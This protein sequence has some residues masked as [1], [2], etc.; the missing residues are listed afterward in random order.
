MRAA[1]AHLLW[2]EMDRQARCSA[3]SLKKSQIPQQPGVYA[4]YRNHRR[5]YV[6]KAANLRSRVGGN[7]LGKGVCLTGSAFR[8]NVAE[9]LSIASAADIKSGRKQLTRLEVDQVC[10][11][12]SACEV[13]W[14]VC[15]SH[16]QACDLERR[17]KH[18]FRPPLTKM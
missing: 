1:P 12:I 2:E 4:W 17:M 7:H 10:L 14:R 9:T 15:E 5:V 8:R 18:E 11:W 3:S 6:G 16:D 13:T